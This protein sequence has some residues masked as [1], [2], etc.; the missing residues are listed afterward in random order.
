MES[1]INIETD[2]EDKKIT[3]KRNECTF[4]FFEFF[5]LSSNTITS[6]RRD[7]EY[8]IYIF[9]IVA[10]SSSLYDYW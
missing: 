7:V 4:Y 5:F 10:D 6:V 1:E 8:K 3:F 2:E 9:P